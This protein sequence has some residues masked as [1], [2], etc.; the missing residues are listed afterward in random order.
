MRVVLIIIKRDAT[1]RRVPSDIC[2][3]RRFIPWPDQVFLRRNASSLS[4]FWIAKDAKFLHA[5]DG[6]Y[7]KSARMRRLILCLCCAH[8]SEGTFSLVVAQMF[9]TH[10]LTTLFVDA[11]LKTSRP[12][13]LNWMHVRLVIRK[14]RVR[15]PTWSA[16]FFRGDW[17]WKTSC[18]HS[19][20]SADSRRAVVS[21]W[22]KNVHN[23]G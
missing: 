22:R 4:A 5:D 17:S 15:P 20:P 10:K 23:T 2:A 7:D 14:L 8:M 19:L 6:D 12:L 16:T 3:Q 13:W 18:G 11:T 1:S 21:F 9:L